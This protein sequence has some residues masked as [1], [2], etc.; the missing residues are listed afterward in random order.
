LGAVLL[1]LAVILGVV[2]RKV[3]KRKKG[4]FKAAGAFY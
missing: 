3:I 1:V 4:K 2:N